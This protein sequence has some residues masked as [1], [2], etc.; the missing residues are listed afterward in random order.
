MGSI[1]VIFIIL[2]SVMAFM[3]LILIAFL[4]PLSGGVFIVVGAFNI[5]FAITGD[6]MKQSGN[7]KISEI[8]STT[9]KSVDLTRD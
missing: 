4:R 2:G 6:K 7:K 9:K 8:D 3:G 5:A 1:K